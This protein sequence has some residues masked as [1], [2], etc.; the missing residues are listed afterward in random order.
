MERGYLTGSGIDGAIEKQ[1]ASI[2]IPTG[3]PSK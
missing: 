3:G 1:L 2:S